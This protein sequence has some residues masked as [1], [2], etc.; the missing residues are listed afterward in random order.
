MRPAGHGARVGVPAAAPYRA[1]REGARVIRAAAVIGYRE[2]GERA[3]LEVCVRRDAKGAHAEANA[4]QITGT[5]GTVGI[6]GTDRDDGGR[7]TPASRPGHPGC[8]CVSTVTVAVRA[9][10]A[11]SAFFVGTPRPARAGGPGRLGQMR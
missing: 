6:T 8:G 5:T 3:P 4:V 10:R 11:C 2:A 7:T 9:W 1:A